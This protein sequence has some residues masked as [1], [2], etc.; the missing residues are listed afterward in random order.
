MD[1]DVEEVPQLAGQVL[2]VHPG[3]AVDVRRIFVR[4]EKRL[5]AGRWA[6]TSSTGMGARWRTFV[7]VLP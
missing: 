7:I 5:Q 1:V 3:A 6:F 2:D 4:Q